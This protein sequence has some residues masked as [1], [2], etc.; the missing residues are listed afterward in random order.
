[1]RMYTWTYS[2]LYIEQHTPQ[3]RLPI[4]GG[5]AMAHHWLH[6]ALR[7]GQKSLLRCLRG[8]LGLGIHGESGGLKVFEGE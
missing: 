2:H 4:D 8:T 3:Q 5:A 6:P 1:M 7:T